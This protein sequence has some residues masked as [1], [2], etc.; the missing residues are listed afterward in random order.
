MA[1]MNYLHP[2]T[3]LNATTE[4]A[5]DSEL[6]FDLDAVSDAVSSNSPTTQ[7]SGG[8]PLT[9]FT[10]QSSESSPLQKNVELAQNSPQYL[11][12]QQK[13][14]MGGYLSQSFGLQ[15]NVVQVVAPEHPP[16]FLGNP[17]SHLV[18]KVE[19]K[20]EPVSAV[21]E[22]VKKPKKI[23]RK[24]RDADMRGP[25]YCKWQACS[26]VF[27][28]PEVLY[29]H[30][31]ND[32]VG[33]K[34]SNNL[35]LTCLWD[36]C[37]T[38]TVKRDHITSHLRVHVPLKPYHCD[39]CPKSFK[40]PQ[41]LKKHTKI[42]EEDHQRSLKKAQKVAVKQPYD[43]AAQYGYMPYQQ[44]QL[45]LDN[46]HF[47]ALGNE[48]SHPE[49]FDNSSALQAQMNS[50]QRKRCADGTSLQQNMHLVNGILNDFYGPTEVNKRVKV[51]PQYNM[52][53]YNRLN[54]MEESL[55]N[56]SNLF[57]APPA[58]S[59][60]PAHTTQPNLYEA[61]KFFSNLSSLIDMQYQSM[62]GQA[63]H[64]LQQQQQQQQPQQQQY[65]TQPLYP[66]L[67]QLLSKAPENNSHFVNN[68]NVG[69]TPSF[70]HASRQMGGVFQSS[71][72]FPVTANFGGVSNSQKSGQKLETENTE[73]EKV[74]ASESDET[75]DMFK[76]L[77]ITDKEFDMD[78]V[79][80]HREIIDLVRKHITEL[81]KQ[82]EE[83]DKKGSE[84]VKS[85]LYPTITAF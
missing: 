31:C 25:F 18:Q 54:G 81:I 21:A 56:Q 61:E 68:H 41:D 70:P 19:T 52:D 44:R 73:N 69:Y 1:S 14:Y 67:P 39:L 15:Q 82:H 85:S 50:D 33:R 53:I 79:K 76:K 57:G 83:Q 28:T 6:D 20:P 9:S 63:S 22:E 46:S 71:G 78:T 10:S 2:V 42:H 84:E 34:C 37:G 13:H 62:A 66:M 45:P 32:H 4:K 40:R 48:M 59:F 74:E 8:S 36:N 24:V 7:S 3:Y 72:S 29:E 60:V 17:H 16:Y 27:D 12:Q 51:E 58:P 26:S 77:L 55:N 30:L 65:L 23:Y 35:S 43:V 11:P 49:L 64:Q 80:R 75:I 5:V 47:T 38:T